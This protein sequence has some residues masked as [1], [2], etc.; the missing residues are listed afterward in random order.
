MNIRR[1]DRQ[2]VRDY[3]DLGGR[4]GSRGTE[5]SRDAMGGGQSDAMIAKAIKV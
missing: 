3:G 5:A 2:A 1:T 4:T